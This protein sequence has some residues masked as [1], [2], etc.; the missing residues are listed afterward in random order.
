MATVATA[1]AFIEKGRA[2]G[3]SDEDIRGALMRGHDDD[4]EHAG[5]VDQAFKDLGG[6]NDDASARRD[7]QDDHNKPAKPGTKPA[8]SAKQNPLQAAAQGAQS[9]RAPWAQSAPSP[10]A[11]SKSVATASSFGTGLAIYVVAMQVLR[12]GYMGPIYWFK[13]KFL[14]KPLTSAGV[15][16]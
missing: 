14:N 2:A 3:S 10:G 13:A 5:I 6:R 11:V 9:P 7:S 8:Q 1:R 12:Y 15:T 4:Q 16:A